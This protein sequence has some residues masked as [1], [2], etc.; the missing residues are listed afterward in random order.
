MLPDKALVVAVEVS[1]GAAE[2]SVGAAEVGAAVVGAAVVGAAVVELS[3]GLSVGDVVVSVG[4]AVVGAAVVGAAV[5]GAAV[6]DADAVAVGDAVAVAEALAV[7]LTACKGSQDSLLPVAVAATALLATMAAA[8]PEAAA[9]RAPPAIKVTVRR[10]PCAIR[11]P[12]ICQHQI[13]EVISG[14]NRSTAYSGQVGTVRGSLDAKPFIWC[15]SGERWA[16][17]SSPGGPRPRIR[18]GQRLARLSPGADRGGQP[19]GVGDR[20]G[21]GRGRVEGLGIARGV[22]RDRLLRQGPWQ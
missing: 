20:P 10:R 14:R 12:N 13:K 22:Q 5:V 15:R 16:N 9:S 6:A 4:A 8:P 18:P 2:V 7:A 21:A 17:R 11:I 1:V 3:V 19:G